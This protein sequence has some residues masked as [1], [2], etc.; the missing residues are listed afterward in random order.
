M[1]PDKDTP[2]PRTDRLLEGWASTMDTAGDA[3]KMRRMVDHA[4]TLE[5]ENAALR[6][7]LDRFVRLHAEWERTGTPELMNMKYA[8]DEAR[9][10]LKEPQT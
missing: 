4:R 5:R 6:K 2:T 9:A 10:A 7:A 1:E 8:E 3:D